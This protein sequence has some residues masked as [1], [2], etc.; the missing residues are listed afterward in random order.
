MSTNTRKSIREIADF[1]GVVCTIS[2]VKRGAVWAVMISH[3]PYGVA[4]SFAQ[5]VGGCISNITVQV[6][7]EPDGIVS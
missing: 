3:A 5:L 7:Y 4:Q 2:C 1:V 6:T